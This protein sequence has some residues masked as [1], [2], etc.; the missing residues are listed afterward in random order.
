MK[1]EELVKQLTDAELKKAVYYSQL[2]FFAI[3]IIL[4]LLFYRNVN[5]LLDII[6]FNFHDIFFYGI[7]IGLCLAS[8]EILLYYFVPKYY[9]DDGGI[10]EK[11]FRNQSIVSIF[12]IALT[13][14]ICEELLFRGVIQTTFG[15]IFAS[16][17]FIIVHIRYF[18]RIVLLIGVTITSFLIGYLFEMTNN[19]LVVIA[20]HF[21]VDFTLGLFISVKNG[22]KNDGK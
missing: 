4:S 10:N 14:A 19:L 7:V 9:F 13:V 6:S 12:F 20:F 3:S 2:L 21:I 18:K 8:I 5:F 16:V 11:L 22:V 15:Y 1:Q 17:L